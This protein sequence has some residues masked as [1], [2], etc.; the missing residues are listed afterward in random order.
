[1]QAAVLVI[2]NNVNCHFVCTISH[3]QWTWF[4][5]VGT[6]QVVVT[7][8]RTDNRHQS[9]GFS[10]LVMHPA[11]FQKLFLVGLLR[12]TLSGQTRPKLAAGHL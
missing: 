7:Y 2:H 6:S 11:C 12:L 10:M 1:M 5:L 9:R 4:N 3:I 8:R